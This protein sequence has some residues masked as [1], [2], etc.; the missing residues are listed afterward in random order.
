MVRR[1]E[2]LGDAQLATYGQKELRSELRTVVCQLI[3]W[4]PIHEHP[5]FTERLGY[6]KCGNS[7]K[8]HRSCELGEA[9]RYHK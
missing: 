8:G 3:M 6:D 5:M 4:S 2:H 9:I 1:G 7:P